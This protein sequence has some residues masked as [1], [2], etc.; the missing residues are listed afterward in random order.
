M[1]NRIPSSGEKP[2]FLLLFI[3]SQRR[4]VRVHM[5]PEGIIVGRNTADTHVDVDM[6]PFNGAQ[7]GVSRAHVVILPKRDRFS[8]KDLDTVN[9][10]WVNKNRLRPN[11]ATDLYH[12]DIVHLGELRVE[13]YFGYE[14][15]LVDNLNTRGSTKR[16]D[17]SEV[18]A[19]APFNTQGSD[20]N[21]LAAFKTPIPSELLQNSS[22]SKQDSLTGEQN[23]SDDLDIN[24]GVTKRFDD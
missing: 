17:N 10:T 20:Q 16:L 13:V 12:G 8:I 3:G 15:D 11:I 14:D 24:P 21:E 1:S 2:D 23:N 19:P 4:P 5:K 9:S 7:H 22:N 18:S 6:T